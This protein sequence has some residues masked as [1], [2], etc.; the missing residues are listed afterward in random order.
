MHA[1]FDHI[2]FVG[3]AGIE[4][5]YVLTVEEDVTY[6]LLKD[7]CVYLLLYDEMDGNGC[8]QIIRRSMVTSL[9]V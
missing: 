5:L 7:E 4:W 8:R 1:E 3:T 2:L 9:R 6:D